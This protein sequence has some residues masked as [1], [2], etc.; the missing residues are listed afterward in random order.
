MNIKMTT[1]NYQPLSLNQ[2]QKQTKETTRRG[3]EPQK[4]RSHKGLSAERGREE[5]GGKGTGNKNNT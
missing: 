2:K 4:L 3:T 5:N 1:N